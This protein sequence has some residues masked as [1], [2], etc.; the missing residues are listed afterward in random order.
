MDKEIKAFLNQKQPN[1]NKGIELLS[2]YSKNSFLIKALTRKQNFPKLIYELN[3]LV[4]KGNPFIIASNI[5]IE[6][7]S[8]PKTNIPSE[9]NSDEKEI[10]SIPEVSK[11][12]VIRGNRKIHYDDLH[13]D[14]QQKWDE[15]TKAYHESRS[16]HEKLKL[17]VKSDP[18]QRQVLIFRM[19]LLGDLIRKN[20]E[21]IDSNYVNYIP[22]FKVISL[23]HKQIVAARK[24][25]STNITKFKKDVTNDKLRLAIQ[26]RITDLNNSNE[27]LSDKTVKLL[28]GLNFEVAH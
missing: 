2:N 21:F 23:D 28:T 11:V 17:M 12:K 14:L 18:K 15:N 24:Y 22:K 9:E 3:K 7:N 10:P 25:I 26:K 4:V 13:K 8:Q 16:L 6:K 5:A 19:I 20:W 27:K 1:Y